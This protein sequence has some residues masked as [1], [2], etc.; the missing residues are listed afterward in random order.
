ML[1][2]WKCNGR[3]TRA[4]AA[5]GLVA[6]CRARQKSEN[7]VIG[8][9]REL[10][11]SATWRNRSFGK[12]SMFLRGSRCCGWLASSDAVPP[13]TAHGGVP[14]VGVYLLWWRQPTAPPKRIAVT[15]WSVHAVFMQTWSDTGIMPAPYG[16]DMARNDSSVALGRPGKPLHAKAPPGAERHFPGPCGTLD[17]IYPGM[18]RQTLHS[19]CTGCA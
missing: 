11:G 1:A 19:L 13:A 7:K 15:H 5:Q 12:T 16:A 10:C 18:H 14:L 17:D 3:S 8:M 2:I 6:H 9:G 4:T